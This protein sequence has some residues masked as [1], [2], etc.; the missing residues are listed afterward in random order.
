MG[1]QIELQADY[2]G[3]GLPQLTETV[4]G[5]PS[6]GLKGL[7]LFEEGV[8]GAAYP[9]SVLDY[10][11]EGAHGTLR[12][13]WGVG[14]KQSYGIQS[15][16]P[17]ISYDVPIDYPTGDWTMIQML[18]WTGAQG[19]SISY[20]CGMAHKDWIDTAGTQV[21]SGSNKK[22]LIVL[23]RKQITG[24]PTKS[25]GIY[26]HLSL[27]GAGGNS[28]RHDTAYIVEPSGYE[29]YIASFEA[30]TGRTTLSIPNRGITSTQL[31]PSKVNYASAFTGTLVLGAM[32]WTSAN[33][34]AAKIAAQGFYNRILSE[35]ELAQIYKGFKSLAQSRGLVLA[36]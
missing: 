28:L 22:G 9:S 12:G 16:D 36:A 20:I 7:Y 8:N 21:S 30:G 11:G 3:L 10:S 5:F 35:S 6:A 17:G 24:N 33:D 27:M 26:D 25:L 29:I 14:T 13:S 23:P 4:R 19:A 31:N 1:L 18:E 32:Q 34:P 15:A 2:R